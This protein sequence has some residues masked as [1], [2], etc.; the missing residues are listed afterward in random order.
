VHLLAV[1]TS[2]AQVSAAL[3]HIA[4]DGEATAASVRQLVAPNRH[5]E[6][7]AQLVH[8]VLAEA[9]VR[10][11]DVGAMAAGLGPGPFTGLRVGVVTAATIA[12][13]CAIP[14]YGVC[15]LDALARRHDEGRVLVCSDA[16]RRQV[17]WA[18]Y[19]GGRR[20]DGPEIGYPAQ[21]AT[22]MAGQVDRTVGAGAL[23]HRDAFAGV[24]S[25]ED[26]P[27][28]SAVDVAALCSQ[29]ALA[30][31]PSEVLEPLYLRRPDAV[32]PGK[33]KTVTPA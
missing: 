17:Y 22:D 31:A 30:G 33:P 2:S 1:D 8:D 18:R 9:R 28:P 19:D 13:A 25:V 10:L 7:L 32:P 12:D 20:V 29:R 3:V 14:A 23:L 16:R 4:P 5:G 27:Y 26:H 11:S 6:L 21:L 24:H 15:S